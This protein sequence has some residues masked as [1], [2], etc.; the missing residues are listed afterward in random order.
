MSFALAFRPVDAPRVVAG[1]RAADSVSFV[2]TTT[3]TLMA[4]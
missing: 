4:T 1:V 2:T 3:T